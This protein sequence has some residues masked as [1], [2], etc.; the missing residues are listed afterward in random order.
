MPLDRP[1]A[2]EQL[3]GYLLVTVAHGQEPQHLRLPL[4]EPSRVSGLVVTPLGECRGEDIRARYG[5][6]G[7]TAPPGPRPLPRAVSRA[8]L[9]L[10]TTIPVLCMSVFALVAPRIAGRIGAE[11]AVLW[12]VVLIGVAVSFD[13]QLLRSRGR[14]RFLARPGVG[15][16]TSPPASWAP[17]RSTMPRP[18]SA[19][20]RFL[21]PGSVPGRGGRNPGLEGASSTA[22]DRLEAVV[23]LIC[24]SSPLRGD[25]SVRLSKPPAC[26]RRCRSAAGWR[27]AP[28]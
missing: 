11:R 22:I 9:G 4:G 8:L 27:G 25:S 20:A 16:G 7:E 5:P 2:Q 28:P 19:R 1:L 3:R 15:R 21:Q 18:L 13:V 23:F 26:R 12:S 24:S 14:P 6:T 10:L 17:R